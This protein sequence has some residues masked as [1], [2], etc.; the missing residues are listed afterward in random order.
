MTEITMTLKDHR[1]SERHDPPR[2]D[3][4]LPSAAGSNIP[5]NI[6]LRIGSTALHR[7]PRSG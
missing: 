2:H 4:D 5:S 6:V 7:G 3:T 1:Q